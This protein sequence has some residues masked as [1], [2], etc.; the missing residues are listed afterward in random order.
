MVECLF[1]PNYLEVLF[2]SDRRIE[3]KLQ[4]VCLFD[5]LMTSKSGIIEQ[6]VYVRKS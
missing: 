1:M 6:L 3:W 4:C 5:S 2:I